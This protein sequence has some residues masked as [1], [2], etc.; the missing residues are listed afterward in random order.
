MY[1]QEKEDA[2]QTQLKFLPVSS[3][4][5]IFA[6]VGERFGFVGMVSVITLYALLILHLLNIAMSTKKD[7][8]V[9]VFASGYGISIL[10]LYGGPM[11]PLTMGIGSQ[12]VGSNSTYV[13]PWR[14][15]LYIFAFFLEF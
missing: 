5:F 14:E 4:D 6:Y 15:H 9:Q 12:V 11:S 7:Y 13:R 10:H 1:G 3:T 2:T 8:F